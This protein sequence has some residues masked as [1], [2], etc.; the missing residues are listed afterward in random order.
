MADEIESI[1]Q[2]AHK[3]QCKVIYDKDPGKL[4][5]NLIDDLKEKFKEDREKLAPVNHPP[6]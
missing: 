2:I 6:D 5:D 3:H 1:T 4:V